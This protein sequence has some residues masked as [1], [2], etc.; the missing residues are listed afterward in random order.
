[1]KMDKYQSA[2]DDYKESIRLNPTFGGAYNGLAW[3]YATCTDGSF[4]D[5][6]KA[7]ENGLK[8]CKISGWKKDVHLDSLAAAYAENGQFDEAV[9]WQKKAT[10]LARVAEKE[11]YRSRIKLYEAKKTYQEE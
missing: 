7:V 6:K 5:G 4:R 11:D 10:E 9:K 2:L 3:I 8:A 1:M